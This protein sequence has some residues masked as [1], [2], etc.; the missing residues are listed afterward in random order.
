MENQIG[1]MRTEGTWA[2]ALEIIAASRLLLRPIHLIIDATRDEDSTTI[3]QPPEI[4][5]ES[6]WGAA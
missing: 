2:T 6:A 3:L 5:V 1:K 4:V